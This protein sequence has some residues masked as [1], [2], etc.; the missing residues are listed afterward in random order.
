MLFVFKWHLKAVEFS[1][2]EDMVIVLVRNVKYSAK[3]SNTQRFKLGKNIR[4]QNHP[5]Y[6]SNRLHVHVNKWKWMYKVHCW[7]CIS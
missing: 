3:G 7:P 5:H 6:S 1:V 2:T 4:V